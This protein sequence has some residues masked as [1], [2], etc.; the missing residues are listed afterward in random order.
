MKKGRR[1][2]YYVRQGTLSAA[3]DKRLRVPAQPIETLVLAEIEALLRSPQRLQEALGVA[4]STI[5][6]MQRFS[7]DVFNRGQL[8]EFATDVLKGVQVAQSEVVIELDRERML[9]KLTGKSDVIE[10]ITGEKV[11]TLTRAY[12]KKHGESSRLVLPPG[13]S[14]GQPSNSPIAHAVARAQ[15]WAQRIVS[16]EIPNQR[17]LAQATGY[18]ERYVSKILPLAFLAPDLVEQILDGTQSPIPVSKQQLTVPMG[19]D[20]Q[21]LIFDR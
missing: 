12:A 18:D 20:E 14:N 1:Y 10:A 7:A 6:A 15:D 2:D 9:R 5:A 13:Y 17:A 4:D 19:W 16:G 3:S 11:I 21:R 8:R